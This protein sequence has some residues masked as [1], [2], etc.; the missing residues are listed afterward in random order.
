[1]F[2]LRSVSMKKAKHSTRHPSY[3]HLGKIYHVDLCTA[4]YKALPPP[5]L[6]ALPNLGQAHLDC[7]FQWGGFCRLCHYN[8]LHDTSGI[9]F[10]TESLVLC[11]PDPWLSSL[12]ATAY[13]SVA[14]GQSTDLLES[15]CGSK[16]NVVRAR[17]ASNH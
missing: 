5:D 12:C 7:N 6:P 8:S 15:S 9:V 10:I 13:S 11:G 3:P 16:A 14:C 4:S 1:M 17:P 2:I